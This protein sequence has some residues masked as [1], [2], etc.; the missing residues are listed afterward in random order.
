MSERESKETSQVKDY[1]AYGEPPQ[2]PETDSRWGRN[3]APTLVFAIP[4]T[5]V[6]Q[7]M[8][9][10]VPHL[11]ISIGFFIG[12]LASFGVGGP[13]ARHNGFGRYLVLYLLM[14]AGISILAFALQTLVSALFI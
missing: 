14:S 9:K 4:F 8:Q 12:G 1:P 5:M 6:F 2:R 13:R 10:W 3:I 7:F 11:A